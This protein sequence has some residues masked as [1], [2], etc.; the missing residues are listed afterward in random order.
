M[1]TA[2]DEQGRF[3]DDE[4]QAFFDAIAGKGSREREFA[5]DLIHRMEADAIARGL[6][7]DPNATRNDLRDA[8]RDVLK[9][10]KE[11]PNA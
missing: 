3:I 7:P 4:S 11:T 8:L 2:R 1:T 10:M 6:I 5:D 9:D